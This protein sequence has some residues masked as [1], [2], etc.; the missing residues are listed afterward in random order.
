MKILL[1]V[2]YFI[3]G[4]LYYSGYKLL[5]CIALDIEPVPP[6]DGEGKSKGLTPEQEVTE[7]LKKVLP[8]LLAAS[9]I[10]ENADE[11]HKTVSD[12]KEQIK[13]LQ[14]TITDMG[15]NIIELGSK[16]I[17]V[18]PSGLDNEAKMD[19]AKYV[20]AIY[21][22]HKSPSEANSNTI[23]EIQDKYHV[24]VALNVGTDAQGGFLVPEPF[25]EKIWRVADEAAIVLQEGL[26]SPVTVG[27]KMPILDLATNVSVAWTAEAANFTQSEPT[28]GKTEVDVKKLGAYAEMTNEVLEDEATGLADFLIQIF[29]EAIGNELDDETFNGDG[30]NFTGI[31]EA[32][33]VNNVAMATGDVD[34][35]D[36]TEQYLSDMISLLKASVLAGAKFFMHRTV[37]NHI[38]KLVDSQGGPIY[39]PANVSQ[40]ATIYGF[41]YRIAEQMPANSASAVSTPF[42]AFG[43]LKNFQFGKKGELSF[44][45]TNEGK[46][47]AIADKTILVV[48]QRIALAVALPAAF[49]KLTTAAV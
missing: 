43:S 37:F 5:D 34:F 7:D 3:I 25:K 11:D 36:V 29:G 46:T 41:P 15:K 33:G 20:V 1:S 8:N 47:L 48:K 6:V 44:A 30:T 32:A 28:F 45:M 17:E 40:P 12:L 26:A 2:I 16:K 14:G 4:I 18:K 49:V 35:E 24:K 31:L 23:K 42:V 22:N 10:L 13:N 19:F 27:N 9:G 38:R 39:A 21:K